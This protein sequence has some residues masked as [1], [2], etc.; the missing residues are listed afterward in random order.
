MK[1]IKPG[2]PAGSAPSAN[3]LVNIA[4]PASI[5]IAVSSAI[6]QS[7]DPNKSCSLSK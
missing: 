5:A 3:T 4:T 1:K 2:P 7:A 6:T